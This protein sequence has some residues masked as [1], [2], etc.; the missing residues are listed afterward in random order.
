MDGIVSYV[1][2]IMR[3]ERGKC[4]VVYF[5]KIIQKC[6]YMEI[7]DFLDIVFVVIFLNMIEKD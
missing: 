2:M 4:V 6:I 5:N 7:D 1:I 3:V